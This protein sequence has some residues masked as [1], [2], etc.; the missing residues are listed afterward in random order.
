MPDC[1]I[2]WLTQISKNSRQKKI[3][4]YSLLNVLLFSE[5]LTTACV[6][7][8]AEYLYG[9]VT[10]T[11]THDP[12]HVIITS[13]HII[14]WL[15]FTVNFRLL[16]QKT[17]YWISNWP[18]TFGKT[19]QFAKCDWSIHISV[20]RHVDNQLEIYGTTHLESLCKSWTLD[21]GLGYGRSFGLKRLML[22]DVSKTVV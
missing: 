15:S 22:P 19:A 16:V 14:C 4:N 13:R 18:I 6:I 7:M 3:D 17:Q 8:S 2:T 21:Y 11:T 1:Q 10:F 20:L 9:F 12:Y 5:T